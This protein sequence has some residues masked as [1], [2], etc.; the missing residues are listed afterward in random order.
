MIVGVG[1]R[2]T[3]SGVAKWRGVCVRVASARTDPATATR[4]NPPNSNHRTTFSQ[5]AGVQRRAA[6]YDDG[7]NHYGGQS[8]GV[9]GRG[10]A[11]HSIHLFSIVACSANSSVTNKQTRKFFF[12][13]S[14]DGTLDRSCGSN[15]DQNPS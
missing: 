10:R 13:A 8:R 2:G 12:T 11:F 7:A 9:L 6:L 1:K 4:W 14:L 5:I 3:G 15:A